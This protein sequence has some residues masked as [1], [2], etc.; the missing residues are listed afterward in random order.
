MQER[1]NDFML[2]SINLGNFK[3]FKSLKNFEIKPL[4]IICGVNS[5]G[6]S[7]ILK[8]LL[9]MKQSFENIQAT[10]VCTT[11]GAYTRNG[12]GIDILHGGKGRDFS[13]GVR[14]VLVHTDYI[15]NNL[16]PAD[17]D[18]VAAYKELSKLFKVENN[19]DI[20]IS[21]DVTFTKSCIISKMLV[22][23]AIGSRPEEITV[24]LTKS[25]TS[26][27]Q[28]Y[29]IALSNFIL[30]Q[31]ITLRNCSC[32]FEGMKLVNIYSH[33]P[34]VHY[35]E[36]LPHLYTL[37][38]HVSKM[39]SGVKHLSPV[40]EMP[41]RH[42]I[43][44]ADYVSVGASGEY[45]AQVI[46]AT[47]RNIKTVHPPINDVFSSEVCTWNFR[48]AVSNWADYLGLGKIDL[49]SDSELLKLMSDGY[50]ISDVG[51]GVSQALPII[52]EALLLRKKQTL[53][54]EQPEIHLHP[55][56]QMN[57]ADFLLASSLNDKN[58]VI[59]THSEHI[60]NRVCRRIMEHPELGSFVKVYFINKS[61]EGDAKVEEIKLDPVGGIMLGSTDFFM[62]FAYE[63]EKMFKLSRI[64][65]K[66]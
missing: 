63:N 22:K 49:S 9:L 50:N 40:R 61:D 62:E 41:A 59:E 52:V 57:M 6:K 56:M 3:V 53:L 10:N 4:T 27:N 34:G 16:P 43:A 47:D 15:K 38:R 45:T 2:K 51:F 32:Y 14:S 5:S 37:M 18:E 35:D 7:T 36:F 12:T 17:K 58:I 24:K 28:I 66:K 13:I 54:M 31:T 39:F 44:D 65:Q 26:K 30:S 64:N 48:K 25:S 60:I 21:L 33:K 23:V 1:G 11:N 8:S 55:R 29:D 46:Q 19:E 20:D 42:Y